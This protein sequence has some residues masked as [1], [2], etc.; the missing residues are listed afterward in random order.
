MNTQMPTLDVENKLKN[1]NIYKNG[2]EISSNLNKFIC[3]YY[4][5]LG[6]NIKISSSR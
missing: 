6:Q 1:N 2:Q 5:S 4:T 3:P